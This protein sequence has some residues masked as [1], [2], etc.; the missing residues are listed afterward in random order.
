MLTGKRSGMAV[1][2]LLLKSSSLVTCIKTGKLEK[3]LV[4][5]KLWEGEINLLCANDKSSI[6][7][8]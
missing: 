3:G 2:H 8:S 1:S 5:S 4:Q 7:I 6:K